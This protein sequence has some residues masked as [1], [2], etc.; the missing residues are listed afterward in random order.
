MQETPKEIHTILI[1]NRGEIALRAIR[2]IKEMGKKAI[3]VYSTA[4]KDAHYL[5]LADAKVCIGGDKSSES[6]LNIPA[7]ISAAELFNAD[8]IFPGYGFLSE[9]QNFVEICKHH[10]IE[11]IG[12][13]PDVMALMSDKSKAKEVMKNAGVPVIPGSDGAVS[14][15]EEALNLAKEIG[16]PVILKAAAGGGGRGM[17]IVEKEEN[18]FNAYL[19]AESEAISAFGDGTIYMEKFIDQPKH[20][21]VQILADKHGNVLHA[22]ERDCSLQRR[23]QKLIE[24]SPAPTL[25]PKTREKLLQTAITATK[26]IKYVGAGTYEFLLDSNQNFY[27]MEMNT[28]LQ[29]EHPVSEL[30]S[31]LDIIELMIRIAEGQSLPKQEEIHFKG[32]AMECRIT[33]EDPVK[34]YPSAGKITK[35][36]APGGGNVRLDTHAYAG[37]VVPMFYDSM[38]GKLIVWGKNR[39]EAIARMSRAL[40]EFCIEGIK[41]TIAFHQEMMK[42][43][44]FK[45]GVIHT[46]YLEQKMANKA[47]KK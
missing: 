12:P 9:N 31:G 23:H 36:I 3:A 8:A 41:T 29:V 2:T 6:Y 5:D 19:A 39:K 21:E 34:F 40:D 13:N 24:E 7:I 15:K 16:Y 44:D 25:E 27:F 32:C 38:I 4:D 30:V 10:K 11:F 35:W 43:E 46:K 45:R 42:N 28:R 17:R 14:S 37:Y 22:G 18:M 20:I 26:A 47:E 33:A 1:A